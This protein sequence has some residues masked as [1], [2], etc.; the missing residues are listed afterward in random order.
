MRGLADVTGEL[1]LVRILVNAL[2]KRA[3][4]VLATMTARTTPL[5][6]PAEPV[7]QYNPGQS[8]GARHMDCPP[9]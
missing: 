9:T 5:P 6:T 2:R 3:N 8:R 7:A 4:E 1:Q